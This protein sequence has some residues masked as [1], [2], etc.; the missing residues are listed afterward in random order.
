[1][2]RFWYR[3]IPE[4]VSIISRGAVA[5]AYHRIEPHLSDYMGTVFEEI[6][7]QYLWSLLLNGKATI[8]F[9]DIGRWWGTN[10]KTRQQVE[11]DILGTA[12]KSTALFGECKWK[13]E[14]VDLGVLETLIERSN[15]FFYENKQYYSFSKSGFTKGCIEKANELGNVTLVSYTEMLEEIL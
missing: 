9:T 6:C 7:K 3:F 8:N 4:N 1:M 15:L 5:L 13:N 10:P 14:K 12:D 2:V 11:I